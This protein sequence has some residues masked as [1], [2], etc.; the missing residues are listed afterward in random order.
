MK[1]SVLFKSL[2]LALVILTL[3]ACNKYE[4][5]SNF[6]LLSAKMR[7]V[8]DWKM[9]SSEFTSGSNTTTN[10]GYTE[11][12]VSFTKDNKY[13]YS[14]KFIGFAF[15]ESGDWE[16]NGDKTVVILKDGNGNV[17]NWQIIKLKNTE[18]KVSTSSNNG[19]LTF[20]FEPK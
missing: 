12:E 8:N 11:V 6:S 13:T 3:A 2:S 10:T 4:E 15:S 18:L 7:L 16:F 17:E 19:T 5:G 1:R 9:V 20:E 14:G